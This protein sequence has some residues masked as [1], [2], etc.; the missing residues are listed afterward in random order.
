MQPIN[1]SLYDPNI[2]ILRGV[3]FILVALVHFSHPLFTTPLINNPNLK[4]VFSL[5]SLSVIQTGWIG[6][7]MFLFISG[8]TLSLGRIGKLN[9]IDFK[10]FYLNRILRL[11]PLWI[12]C[13][14]HLIVFHKISGSDAFSLFF[15]QMQSLPKGSPYNIAWSLQLEWACYIFF[16][17]VIFLSNKNPI[18]I[19]I[20]LLFLLAYRLS[21]GWISAY[22]LF[23]V[24]Y[25]SIFG[26][27]TIFAIGSICS[28]L[29]PI[30]NYLVKFILISSGIVLLIG[31][32]YF[33]NVNGGYQNGSG[34]LI[35][36]F[37]LFLPE[38]IA[39]SMCLLIWGSKGGVLPGKIEPIK[40]MNPFY[41]I[42]KLPLILKIIFAHVGKISY[43]GYIFSILILGTFESTHLGK[44]FRIPSDNW[45]S[46]LISF[47]VYLFVLIIFSSLS[48]YGIEKP[49][50]D[51]RRSAI[52]N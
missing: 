16:P 32:C 37:F 52:K 48:F 29:N 2:D 20:L 36:R 24:S 27:L 23:E 26:G 17:I 5:I 33:V 49:F 34:I 1:K 25:S 12:L 7:P 50:L 10:Q 6:V 11:S 14:A 39:F 15:F 40:M 9:R 41:L 43:S 21:I 4:D 31:F 18:K 8:Y 38:Y 51:L 46:L 35:R 13:I 30:K 42:F 45:S 44:E 22:Q 19:S 28:N 47:S 3:A